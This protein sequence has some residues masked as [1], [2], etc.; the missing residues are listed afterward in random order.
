MKKHL[1][2]SKNLTGVYY[3]CDSNGGT[4][5]VIYANDMASAIQTLMI[6]ELL[7]V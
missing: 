4:H 6:Q 2:A 3:I 5:G 7:G 1:E